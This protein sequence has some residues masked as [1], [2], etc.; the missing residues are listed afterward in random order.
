MPQNYFVTGMP[1]SGKTTLLRRIAKRLREQGLRVGGF[2]SPEEKTHGTRTGFYVQDINSGKIAELADINID[3]PK[4][5]KYHVN[6]KSFESI[7]LPVLTRFKDYDV[8]IVDEIG[9]MELKSQQF[10]DLLD[11]LLESNTPLIA[12]LHNDLV[13]KYGYYGE[14][15]YLS[16][17]TR[18][19][20]YTDLI[21]KASSIKEGKRKPAPRIP[22]VK[23]M[24][25]GKN[26][27]PPAPQEKQKQQKEK[28]KERQKEARKAKRPPEDEREDEKDDFGSH[29]EEEEERSQKGKRRSLMDKIVDLLGF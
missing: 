6:V 12:S 18:E 2:T 14:V 24:K 3:G 7:A 15:L 1:R 28:E 13:D 16:E 27:P 22:E 11:E 5:S 8:I 9:M 19:F 10:A 23:P 17:D 26:V 20:L 29:Y 4:I 21:R 25:E